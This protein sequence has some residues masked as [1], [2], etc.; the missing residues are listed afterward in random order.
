MSM[1]RLIED[2]DALSNLWWISP[3]PC[4][5]SSSNFS[6]G[7]QFDSNESPINYNWD[8]NPQ[9]IPFPWSQALLFPYPHAITVGDYHC[10]TKDHK[11]IQ[12][13][14]QLKQHL[15]SI[16]MANPLL[17]WSRIRFP[18]KSR[19]KGL[20]QIRHT[21]EMHTHKILW[22]LCIYLYCLY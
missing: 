8:S 19:H 10:L 16:W 14:Q 4:V 21:T 9:L 1:G 15:D 22:C 6:C 5:G 17:L 11:V 2:K 7:F 13:H 12:L 18:S 20:R 3:L